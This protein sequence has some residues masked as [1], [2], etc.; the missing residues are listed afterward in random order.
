M[1]EALILGKTIA[2]DRQPQPADNHQRAT[3]GRNRTEP[4][5]RAKCHGVQAACK[6]QHAY[7]YEPSTGR[8]GVIETRQNSNEQQ[9]KRM[10]KPI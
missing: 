9:S 1:L 2:S 3:Y 7:L 5:R 8:G 4:A 6:N 10:D